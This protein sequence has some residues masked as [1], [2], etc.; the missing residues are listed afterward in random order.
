[1]SDLGLRVVS[2]LVL[3]P[4]VLFLVW[5]GNPG[6]TLLVAL[7][8]AVIAWEWNSITR[9]ATDRAMIAAA[10][11]SIMAVLAAALGQWLPAVLLL[12]LGA[13]VGHALAKRSGKP[14]TL[15]WLGVLYAA[16]PA[17]ALVILRGDADWGRLAVF[18]LL[19]IVWGTDIGAYSAGRLIGGPKL[20]PAISPNK[21]WAGSVG[22]IAAALT[23][24]LAFIYLFLPEPVSPLSAAAVII[25]LSFAAQVGDLAES[26]LKRMFDVKDSSNLIPG[27]GGV[28]DR[29]D[30]L[31]VA[32]LVAGVVGAARA[33]PDAAGGGLLLW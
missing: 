11:G 30:G 2:A 1:M 29:V 22:G 6:F 4:L 3:G 17:A 33:G 14:G 25:G 24:G 32:A 19:L 31:V 15:L 21:T 28:M 13:A 9:G 16:L 12:V 20:W 10:G 8:T 5:W 18:W 7:G 23:I 27:H 26:K